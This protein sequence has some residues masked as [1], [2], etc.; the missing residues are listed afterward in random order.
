[1]TDL[2]F[3]QRK[4]GHDCPMCPDSK[5]EDVVATLTS[6]KVHLQND[7]DYPG[8]CVLTFHRHAVEI[9]DLTEEERAHWIE[10]VAKVSRRVARVSE[11][12]KVN[13]AM[14]GNMVPHLHCHVIPRFFDDPDWNKAPVFRS[15]DERHTLPPEHYAELLAEFRIAFQIFG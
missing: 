5:E 13:I 4:Q 9:F 14:F 8:W 2:Q 12:A 7:A 11:C 1:M 10:D 6:G 3:L 15:A